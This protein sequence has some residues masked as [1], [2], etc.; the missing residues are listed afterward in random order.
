MENFLCR[1]NFHHH[2]V[3]KNIDSWVP[4]EASIHLLVSL[5]PVQ[6]E[7]DGFSH[8]ILCETQ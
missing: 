6:G 8:L 7:T 3:D 2:S 5:F 1:E 4:I